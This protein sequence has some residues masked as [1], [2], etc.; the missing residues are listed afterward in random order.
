ME[1]NVR[2]GLNTVGQCFE[3]LEGP[4][5]E[6]NLRHPLVSVVVIALMAVLAGADGPTS[7]A[8]WARCKSDLLLKHLDL[9]NG[10]PRKDCLSARPLCSE[11]GRVSSLFCQLAPIVASA[12]GPSDGN[13][14]AGFG[15]GWQDVAAEPRSTQRI[16]RLAFGQRMGLG[17]RFGAGTSGLRAEIER[18]HGDSRSFETGEHERRDHHH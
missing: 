12:S 10:I 13:R 9:P 4:R 5:S 14:K 7:I 3:S 1:G 6:I 18:N 11:S 15:G 16:G 8:K 17:L 2:I